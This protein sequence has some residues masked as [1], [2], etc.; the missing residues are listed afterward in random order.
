MAYLLNMSNFQKCGD[1]RDA[2]TCFNTRLT[3]SCFIQTRLDHNNP[4]HIND[5]CNNKKGGLDD[6]ILQMTTTML[7]QCVSSGYNLNGT[8]LTPLYCVQ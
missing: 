8:T 1:F 6:F 7:Q 2:E 4:V 3:N 5:Y